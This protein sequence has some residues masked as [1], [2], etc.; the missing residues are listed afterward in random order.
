MGW[1]GQSSWLAHLGVHAERADVACV[2]FQREIAN[3]P[4]AAPALLPLSLPEGPGASWVMVLHIG[5]ASVKP[6]TSC[7]PSAPHLSDRIR[8]DASRLRWLSSGSPRL[9][10]TCVA[11]A[12]QGQWLFWEAGLPQP[13]RRQWNAIRWPL[14]RLMNPRSHGRHHRRFQALLKRRW[15]LQCHAALSRNVGTR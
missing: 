13:L 4:H 14:C 11:S 10:H 2:G 12:C 3:K 8:S 9:P 7:H 1:R 6:E 5:T 15:T